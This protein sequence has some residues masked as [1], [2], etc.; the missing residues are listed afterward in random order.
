MIESSEGLSLSQVPDKVRIL[1]EALSRIHGPVIIRNEHSGLHLY[2]ASPACLQIDGKKELYS[3]HLTVNA[4]KYLRLGEF[5]KRPP[6][7]DP[8]WSAK[9]HK[10]DKNYKVSTLLNMKPL[11][12]RGI[13]DVTPA[14]VVSSTDREAFLIED[15]NGNRIPDHPGEVITY[16]SDISKTLWNTELT[17]IAGRE[18]LEA[19]GYSL[20][21]LHDQFRISV[22]TIE[23][24]EDHTTGRFYRRLPGSFRDTPQGRIVFY[25]DIDGIQQGWQA[26]ILERIQKDSNGQSFKEYFHPYKRTWTAVESLSSSG[27]WVLCSPFREEG[28]LRWKPS[29]YKTAFGMQRSKCLMGID[30]ADRWNKKMGTSTAFLTEGPLDAGRIGPPGLSMMGKYLNDGQAMLLQRYARVVM[31]AD[32]D[33]AG[34]EALERARRVLSGHR[35]IEFLELELPEG[36]KDLGDMRTKDAVDLIIPYIK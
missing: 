11:A 3:R 22:C 24:P 9:C 7:K 33:K 15:E 23:R 1:A 28:P 34:T 10:T 13:P 14:V 30:A 35:T 18:Y 19:R 6:R 16:D 5:G 26:R 8:D 32:R 2:M 29:K 12:E 21:L 36:Y 27:D 20:D 31:V 17:A 25:V 4:T